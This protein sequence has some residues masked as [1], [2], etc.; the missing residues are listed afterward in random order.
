MATET[1]IVI[2]GAGLVGLAT[3]VAL[4]TEG[5]E[6]TL[7]DQLAD[8]AEGARGLGQVE[9]GVL[10][11][12]QRTLA[13]LG[14][15]DFH[16]LLAFLRRNRELAG[17]LLDPCGV[18][19]HAV[20]D[21]E[22]PDLEEAA[23]V[24]SEAGEDVA[25]L[26]PDLPTGTRMAVRLAGW[27]RIDPV[28]TVRTLVARAETLGVRCLFGTPALVL[29]TDPPTVSIGEETLTAELLVVAAGV[30]SAAL[31]PR[32]DGSLTPIREAAAAFMGRTDTC[33]GRAGQGWTTWITRDGRTLVSGCRWATPHLEVGE[34]DASVLEPR[35]HGRID[36]FATERLGCATP[37]LDRWAWITCDTRDHLPLIGPI[38]GQ[39]RVLVAT[40]FGPNPA[41]WSFA[42]A[43]ALADGILHGESTA[44]TRLR[45]SR[46][47]RWTRG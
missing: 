39:P 8:P 42:A 13:A 47:V 44:P 19:W 24:W 25:I 7:V 15:D 12:P 23:R 20:D 35:V 11:H 45:T 6:V 31:V 30:D 2:V 4:A 46:L 21:R 34:A 40:G 36:A 16:D 43:A 1:Q 26:H 5:V 14:H 17:D 38:P 9:P 33:V 28:R 22:P 41:S 18:T 3:A 27:G 37:A 32:L 29:D 10:E